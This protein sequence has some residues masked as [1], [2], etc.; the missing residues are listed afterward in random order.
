M[1]RCAQELLNVTGLRPDTGGSARSR[2]HSDCTLNHGCEDEQLPLSKSFTIVVV[3]RSDRRHVEPADWLPVVHGRR[4]RHGWLA[5]CSD[6][7]AVA[8]ADGCRGGSNV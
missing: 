7:H 2:G 1:L 3:K 8:N 4:L 5:F 6:S